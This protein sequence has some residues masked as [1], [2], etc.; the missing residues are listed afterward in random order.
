M[1]AMSR[2]LVFNVRT[3]A[4]TGAPAASCQCGCRTTRNRQTQ[5]SDDSDILDIPTMNDLAEIDGLTR[6]G[7]QKTSKNPRDFY[8]QNP[9]RPY[10]KGRDD[11]ASTDPHSFDHTGAGTD[12]DGNPYGMD[13]EHD[14][15]FLAPRTRMAGDESGRIVGGP[16]L[17]EDDDVLPLPT[18]ALFDDGRVLGRIARERLEREQQRRLG[19]VGNREQNDLALPLPCLSY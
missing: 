18:S 10:V 1:L 5:E 17:D 4:Q 6:N 19:L 9:K 12:L 11:R 7:S 13:A 2:E 16:D 8:D 15:E 14:D 3:C